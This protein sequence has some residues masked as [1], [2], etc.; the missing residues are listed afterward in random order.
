MDD[1]AFKNLKPGD[2]VK[3]TLS[4]NRFM[5]HSNYGDRVTAVQ[6][7]DLTNPSEW[8]LTYS[9]HGTE[10]IVPKEKNW[11][12]N[13][14]LDNVLLGLSAVMALVLMVIISVWRYSSWFQW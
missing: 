12:D 2:V 13:I 6:T 11:R 7:A 9:P 14:T 4:G 5:V 1:I 3:N 10:P 8:E